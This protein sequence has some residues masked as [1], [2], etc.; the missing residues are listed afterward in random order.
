M[1]A[2]TTEP[3]QAPTTDGPAGPSAGRAR[4]TAQPSASAASGGT[5]IRAKYVRPS[6]S[7]LSARAPNTN[8]TTDAAGTAAHQP[9]RKRSGAGSSRGAGHT[10]SAAWTRLNTQIDTAKDGIAPSMEHPADRR[11]V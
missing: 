1:R 2:R 7:P 10:T 6:A 8:A 4:G 11:G 5:A 3:P 9:M